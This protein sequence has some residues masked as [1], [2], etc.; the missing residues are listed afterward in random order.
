M[1]I[2]RG[3]A[4]AAAVV[5]P[6]LLLLDLQTTFPEDW[7]DHLWIIGYYGEYFHQHGELP[8]MVN[9]ASAV[10]LAH[11][12]FY[13]YLL[14]PLLAPLSAVL[15]A[16][17][18]LRVGLVLIT[19]IQFWATLTAGRN[20]FRNAGL[21]YT[22][23]ASV[24]WATY[25]L[26]NLYN[27]GAIA[28][29]FATAC[30]FTAVAFTTAMATETANPR[31]YFFGWLA[32]GFL[33]LTAGAHP[34]T[35]VLTGAFIILLGVG[36]AIS[37]LSGQLKITR[38]AAVGLCVAAGLGAAILAPWIYVCHLFGDKLSVA[39][40]SRELFFYF[41]KCDSLWG[42]FAPYPYDLQS[43]ES[44]IYDFGTAYLEA[45]INVVL[46]AILAWN[47]ELCRRAR[48]EIP[49][50]AAVSRFTAAKTILAMAIAWFVFLAA[51]SVSPSLATAFR[52]FAPYIQYAYRLVSHCNVALLVAVFT[53]GVLVAKRGG[54]LRFQ[55]ETNAVVAACLAIAA[56]GLL[57]KLQ[58]A[59][60][61]TKQG[62]PPEFTFGSH[63]RTKL[64]SKLQAQLAG[65]YDV[66]SFVPELEKI[67]AVDALTVVLPVGLTG[68][69]FG[70]V[71]STKFE[72]KKP[73]WV[74]TNVVVFPWTKLLVDGGKL[75]AV[76]TAQKDHFFAVYLPEGAHELQA[77]FQ[78][79]HLWVAL[80]R[81]SQITVAI[82]LFIN[83]AW[84]AVRLFFRTETGPPSTPA[85][86]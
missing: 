9:I 10:G 11:P 13:G 48:K 50:P 64:I 41:E 77:E 83:V 47:L 6:L 2:S 15:G 85:T 8:K 3:V 43:T 5:A 39:K 7:S 57:I 30:L 18:A 76:Q 31:R 19:T 63:D 20:I 75:P 29:Y 46:L 4:Y 78:P 38:P 23:A 36:I 52:F 26:T 60:V 68:Q 81:L 58:H 71:G 17:L 16:A 73:G 32:G 40:V 51:V 86:T 25:S 66:P 70:K 28:E 49:R 56:L 55:P 69:E 37:V 44:G 24:V 12:I 61:V 14:Y 65:A 1:N 45:P 74:T 72:M 80:H 35:A 22:V 67:K 34:P 79:D 84:A 82:V 53:S 27:R 42:R 33:V 59:G 62:D 21:N 54:Y